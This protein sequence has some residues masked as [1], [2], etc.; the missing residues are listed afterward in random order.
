MVMDSGSVY[1]PGI[2]GGIFNAI[3]PLGWMLLKRSEAV[4]STYRIRLFS[5]FDKW[6]KGSLD[7]Y[8]SFTGIYDIPLDQ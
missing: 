7:Q 4:L 6:K 8:G 2:F 5:S 3:S 1:R